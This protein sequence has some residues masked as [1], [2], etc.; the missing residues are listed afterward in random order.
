MTSC[1]NSFSNSPLGSPHETHFPT[2]GSGNVCPSMAA[3]VDN[4]AWTIVASYFPVSFFSG[5][6]RV[7]NKRVVRA[8]NAAS[9]QLS[10]VAISA[11]HEVSDRRGVR[12]QDLSCAGLVDRDSDHVA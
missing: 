9:N 10:E 11:V 1:G 7:M 4:F 12:K 6:E 5:R 8:S 2:T 3:V